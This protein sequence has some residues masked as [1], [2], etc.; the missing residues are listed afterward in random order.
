MIHLV[1]RVATDAPAD[2]S[3]TMPFEGRRKTRQRV[4]LD[5]GT[6]AAIL[7]PPGTVLVDG[8]FLRSEDGLLVRIRAA[9]EEVSSARAGDALL[10]A[11]ACYHLGNR[12]VPVQ[13]GDGLVRYLHDHVLDDMLRALGLE[14]TEEHVC[15]QPEAGAYHGHSALHGHSH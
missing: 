9:A 14:V 6:E 5:C 10:L 8:D 1:E 7:L 13:V 2:L 11:R 3:L 15:F 12:H 4:T